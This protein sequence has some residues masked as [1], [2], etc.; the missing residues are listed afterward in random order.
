MHICRKLDIRII[1]N[2]DK[3]HCRCRIDGAML[4]LFSDIR[5]TNKLDYYI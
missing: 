5:Y 1:P 4:F 3:K 2:K